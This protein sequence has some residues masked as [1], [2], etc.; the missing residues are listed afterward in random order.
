MFDWALNTPLSYQNTWK[1]KILYNFFEYSIVI[2][3]P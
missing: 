2:S 1:Q 3:S